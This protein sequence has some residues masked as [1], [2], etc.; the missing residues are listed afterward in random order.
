MIKIE[1]DQNTT[2]V[3]AKGKSV[4]LL[5]E[6]TVMVANAFRLAKQIANGALYEPFK[7]LVFGQF[8]D[9]SFDKYA[10]EACSNSTTIQ[11][12]HDELL[13]QMQEEEGED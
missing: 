6:T 9:G 11:I 7:T 13:R 4:D 2:Q 12:N 1:I 3:E 5:A 8:L 10:N